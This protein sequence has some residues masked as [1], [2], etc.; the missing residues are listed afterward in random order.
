[1]KGEKSRNDGRGRARGWWV[2]AQVR[3]VRPGRLLKDKQRWNEKD[4]SI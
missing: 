3:S 1:V 2:G 4:P